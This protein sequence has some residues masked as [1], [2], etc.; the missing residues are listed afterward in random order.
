MSDSNKSYEGTHTLECGIGRGWGFFRFCKFWPLSKPGGGNAPLSP[1]A[2]K[3]PTHL[4]RGQSFILT[5]Y[6]GY[7]DPPTKKGG[8]LFRGGADLGVLEGP[9]VTKLRLNTDVIRGGR[10]VMKITSECTY[11]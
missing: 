6:K 7:F 4:G 2:T 11:L 8:V 1:L 5:V 3:C 9:V 10:G